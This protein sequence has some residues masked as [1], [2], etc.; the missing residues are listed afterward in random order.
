MGEAAFAGD[1]PELY[2]RHLGPVI[3]AGM[4]A[5]MA[6]CVAAHRPAR[7]LETA[8]GTGIVTR[9]LRDALPAG[10]DLLA[11]DL[12]DG[13]L[14]VAR[15]KFARGERVAFRPA[16]AAALPFGPDSFDAAVC[17]FGLMFLPDMA[18]GVS[19]MRRVLA[20]G[21]RAFLSIW[22]SH[23]RNPFGRIAFETGAA[24]CPADPPPFPR[25]PFSTPPEAVEAALAAA[26]FAD[27]TRTVV[28]HDQPLP[29]AASFARGMIFGSPVAG[30][31][32]DRG[33][34]PD[35]AVAALTVAYRA[36]FGPDPATMPIQAVF[37][38]AVKRD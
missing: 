38:E 8:A 37:F 9:A 25:V 16:D 26:G 12:Q 18:A 28:R 32:R 2:D 7:V 13:M 3:F 5:A 15:G 34:D 23:A 27:V 4:A 31:I 22:D 10:A 11:T 29:D 21:G 36:A 1:I 24:L 6:V 14:E 30:Q 35:A 19:E 20:P 33:A 17:Q